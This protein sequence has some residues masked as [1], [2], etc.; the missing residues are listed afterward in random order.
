VPDCVAD[1]VLDHVMNQV[2]NKVQDE[3]LD[4]GS[5]HDFTLLQTNHT[6]DLHKNLNEMN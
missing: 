5:D 6:L 2:L 3:L 4:R 1:G